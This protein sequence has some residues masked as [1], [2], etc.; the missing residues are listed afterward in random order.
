MQVWHPGPRLRCC[1]FPLQGRAHCRI[2]G[3]DRG[4]LGCPTGPQGAAGEA[5]TGKATERGLLGLQKIQPA[6]GYEGRPALRSCIV[7]LGLRPARTRPALTRASWTQLPGS[8]LRPSSCSRPRKATSGHKSR[9]AVP[10]LRSSRLDATWGERLPLAPLRPL[11][12]LPLRY[13]CPFFPD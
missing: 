12:R 3:T 7:L 6:L 8:L 9:T 1:L 11:R 2:S 4:P 13:L 10:H 5:V